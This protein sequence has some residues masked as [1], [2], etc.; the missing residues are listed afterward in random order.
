MNK[1]QTNNLK[2]NLYRDYFVAMVDWVITLIEERAEEIQQ[3]GVL[4]CYFKI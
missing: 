1:I 4:F 3:Q 2:T